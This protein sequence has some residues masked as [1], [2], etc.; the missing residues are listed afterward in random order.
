MAGAAGM[1]VRLRATAALAAICTALLAS[2]PAVRA[3]CYWT[4]CSV[5]LSGDRCEEGDMAIGDPTGEECGVLK[6]RQ[7]CCALSIDVTSP[8]GAG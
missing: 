1:R 8:T 4:E 6:K 3:D 7:Y 2:L 5:S